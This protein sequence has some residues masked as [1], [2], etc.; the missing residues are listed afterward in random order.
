MTTTDVE[1]KLFM[2]E[3][4]VGNASPGGVAKSNASSDD[5]DGQ[6][7]LQIFSVEDSEPP[8]DFES[9]YSQLPSNV[10]ITRVK[11]C[12]FTSLKM[13]YDSYKK[14]ED[15]I[16]D[17]YSLF[18]LEHATAI[19]SDS[20]WYVICKVFNAN[21]FPDHEEWFLDRIATNYV[22]FTLHPEFTF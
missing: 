4:N 9:P 16:N 1:N 17:W 21:K 10:V 2:G 5:E 13:K 12:V 18:S 14:N 19:I 20:F 15:A 6:E 7:Q 11:K 22:S 8:N 3:V